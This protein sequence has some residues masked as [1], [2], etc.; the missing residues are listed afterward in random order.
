MSIRKIIQDYLEQPLPLWENDIT[1][2]LVDFKWAELASQSHIAPNTYTIAR[3]VIGK[4][5]IPEVD[6]PLS[7]NDCDIKIALPSKDLDGFYEE[8]GIEPVTID[9]YTSA[10]NISKIKSALAVI[11]HVPEAYLF[12]N[13]IVKSI[14]IIEA[15]YS[16]TDISYSH[17]GIPF[18]IFFSI[19]EE[20]SIISDLRVAESI[21]HEAMHLKL[22]LIESNIDLIRPFSR[23][24]FYSPWRDENRPLRGVLHGLF[25]F[26]A[27]LDFYE[28]LLKKSIFKNAHDYLSDRISKIKS[29]I[30]LINAFPQSKDLT[31][32]GQK[33]SSKL[34]K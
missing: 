6:L 7:I 28:I 12:I 33:L 1:N 19:C 8:H 27:I 13:H 25:V 34:L 31:I 24:T 11:Q 16:D 20:I 9:T 22:T 30:R 18:S 26:R 17:P 21:L 23:E 3:C 32:A 5:N 2:L 14:Q 4:I 29:E 10:S 15:E